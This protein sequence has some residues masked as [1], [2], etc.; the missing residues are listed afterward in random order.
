MKCELSRGYFISIEG[1]DGSGKSTQLRFI[2]DYMDE[3]GIDAVFTR[4]PGG[5]H[6]GEMLRAIILDKSYS[7]MAPMTETLLYAA[8]RAQHVSEKIIP[9][10]E[11]GKVVICDRFVDS[12]IAYQ[13]YGRELGESVAVING[14]ATGGFM[15]D[16]T[17]FLDI[18]PETA[19]R[20]IA[21]ERKEERD[22]IEIQP[23][24][25]HERVYEGYAALIKAD[26][27]DGA[28]RFAV[29]DATR[30]PEAVRNEI[31]ERL[32]GLFGIQGQHVITSVNDSM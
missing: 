18:S 10:V 6:I 2:A 24:T 19:F 32:D 28:G 26:D 16:L 23:L 1:G 31:Y 7:E 5:T 14:Y 11:A 22:R 9:A 12:S 3:R 8:S 21:S 15:P 20:R 29:I 17:I 30:A 4:E 25:F 13:G 27:T